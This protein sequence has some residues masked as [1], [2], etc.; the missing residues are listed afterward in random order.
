MSLTTAE[1]LR[2]CHVR[3]WHIVQVAREQTLAEH[4]FAVAV[5][6][7]SLAAAVRWPGL[8]DRPKQLQLLQWSLSHDLIEVRTGD[9]PTPFKRC[10]EQVGGPGIVEKAEDVVDREHMGAYRLI[11]GTEVEVLVKLADQIEAIYFL[12]D[13]G[14][15]A[16]A[17]QVLDGLRRILAEM[18]TDIEREYP[19]LRMREGVREV[20]QDIGIH[21]GWL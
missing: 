9:M 18:V 14:I 4:S 2:A 7:G 21:G 12:Q 11:K 8:L 6:A 15:G 20:C 17:K 1:Q 16:H 5:I 3:R 13:N 10:L 19:K